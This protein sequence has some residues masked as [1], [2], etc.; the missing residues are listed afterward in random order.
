MVRQAG[1]SIVLTSHS[2]E[3][4]EALCQRLLIMVNARISCLGSPLYLKQKY[5]AGYIVQLKLKPG[6]SP[7]SMTKVLQHKWGESC[8]FESE[9]NLLC[10]YKI[11]QPDL[12][13]S[14]LFGYVERIK[15]HEG[16]GLIEDYA[17]CQTSIERIFLSLAAAGKE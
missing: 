5:G 7:D 13:L 9:C 17:I 12:K 16:G 8:H 10:T 6:S 1:S 4:C 15:D 11:D 3:E 2:M 14:S